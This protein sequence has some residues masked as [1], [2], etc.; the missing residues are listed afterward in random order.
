[1]TVQPGPET[2]DVVVIGAGHNS[3]IAAAYL[4]IAGL[5]VV[6]LEDRPIVG[7]NTVTEELTLPGHLHDSCSSAHVLLQ[8]NPAVRDDELGLA[9]LGLRYVHTDPAVVLP[10]AGGTSLVL[11]RDV[12]R[13]A[14]EIA[15]FDTGDAHAFRGMLADWRNGLGAAHSRWN[16]GRLDPAG[17]LDDAT[18]ARL[19]SGSAIDTIRERFRHPRIVD[20]MAWM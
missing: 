14:A 16:A 1:M 10:F 9:E 19:R 17:N 11:H 4:A 7:G 12:E 20:A 2:A 8:S 13:S 3:L 15:R 6:V 5:E 18:Y